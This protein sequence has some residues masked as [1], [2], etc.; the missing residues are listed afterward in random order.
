MKTNFSVDNACPVAYIAVNK[1][2]VKQYEDTVYLKNGTEFSV[3]LF[4]PT[5]TKVSA[6][7]ELNGKS[8]GQGI[9]VRPGERIFLDRHIQEAK[10][11][12][13]ETYKV[14]GD[15]DEVQ[16]AIENNGGLIVKFHKEKEY[17]APY[18]TYGSAPIFS[19]YDN[20]GGTLRSVNNIT[21]TNISN[22]INQNY[23]HTSN[24]L[25]ISGG[26]FNSGIV[27]ASCSYSS[28]KMGFFGLEQNQ[29]TLSKTLSKEVETGIIEKGSY[30][31]QKLKPDYT[32]FEHSPAW[33]SEW[34]ILPESRRE[35]VSEDLALQYCVKDGRKRRKNEAYC[36]L[37]GTKF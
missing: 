37:C 19:Y 17:N 4:N 6:R 29:K 31:D 18:Y 13:F 28:G 1:Q 20:S 36:P 32:S 10:K 26:D 8:I 35:V 25:N 14:N 9:I 23:C 33:K 30:S 3:E 2:R 27:T 22:P 21:T 5:N 15:S 12:L 7:I 24:S 11:F 16:K 34:K